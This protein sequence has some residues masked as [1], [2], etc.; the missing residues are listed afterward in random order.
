MA[1]FVAPIRPSLELMMMKLTP[2]PPGLEHPL[3]AEAPV[4]IP[5]P[6]GLEH[7]RP[8]SAE[9]PVF[10]PGATLSAATL[11][12]C[13]EHPLNA[14]AP[15]FIPGVPVSAVHLPPGLEHSCSEK[16]PVCTR[17]ASVSVDHFALSAEAPVFTPEVSDYGLC[18]SS[19]RSLLMSTPADQLLFDQNQLGFHFNSQMP[20]VTVWD[21]SR[22]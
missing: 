22:L 10:I 12:P 19:D 4:F 11:P 15:V 2:F 13:L 5:V 9:A 16:A 17:G 21:R 18:A 8:L 3:S 7:E 1:A 20:H 14:D 6:P